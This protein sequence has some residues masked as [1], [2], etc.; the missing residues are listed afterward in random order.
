MK[1]KQYVT[2]ADIIEIVIIC[3]LLVITSKLAYKEGHYAGMEDICGDK[4]INIDI[5]GGIFCE[6]DRMINVGER[7]VQ[8]GISGNNPVEIPMNEVFFDANEI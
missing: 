1:T 8:V 3:L 7:T 4:Q 6:E 2:K 5:N